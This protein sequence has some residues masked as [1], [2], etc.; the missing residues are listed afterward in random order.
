MSRPAAVHLANAQEHLRRLRDHL[1]RG[2][3]ADDT[4]FDAVCMRLS[5]AI[6]SVSAIDDA[7]RDEEFGRGWSAIWSVRNR[8]AHGYF[9][10]D[11]QIITSTVEN[12]LVE[13]EA[14]VERLI[15]LV[16]QADTE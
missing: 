10:V 1:V 14:G 2:D 4:I 11:R 9:Y 8:I 7:L 5:A 16:D 3:L 15:R 12:D 6:E 13:F